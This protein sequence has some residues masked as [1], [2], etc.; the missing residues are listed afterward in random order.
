MGFV[1]SVYYQ[2]GASTISTD[3]GWFVFYRG[4][5]GADA[6]HRYH[7]GALL[8]SRKDPD[9][10]LYR[11]PRSVLMPESAAET[12]WV[13]NNGIFPCRP[14]ANLMVSSLFTVAWVTVGSMGVLTI[15]LPIQNQDDNFPP[16]DE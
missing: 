2:M 4:V 8:L 10:I 15:C 6:D 3:K 12:T 11:S 13:V 1:I 14:W 16:R 7:D 9:K 5:E